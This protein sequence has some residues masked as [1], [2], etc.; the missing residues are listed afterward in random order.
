MFNLFKRRPSSASRRFYGCR[1]RVH[2]RGKIRW[3]M[4]LAIGIIGAGVRNVDAATPTPTAVIALSPST[5]S[6]GASSRITWSSTNSTSCTASGNWAWTGVVATSGSRVTSQSGSSLYH[7]TYSLTCSGAA[8]SAS[9]S[10]VLTVQPSGTPT[11]LF[12]ATPSSITVGGSATLTWSSANA[13]SCAASGAWSGTKASSG[14]TSVTPTTGGVYTYTLIC[15]GAGGS[16][17]AS[18]SVTVA[19]A[20]QPGAM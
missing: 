18:T 6:S 16:G 7:V 13:T 11:V 5:I 19:A 4:L 8:G 10:A 14:T 15:A 9:S 12:V 2:T 1:I 20:G 3:L 17:S